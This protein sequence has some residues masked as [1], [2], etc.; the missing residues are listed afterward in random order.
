MLLPHTDKYGAAIKAEKFRRL[1]EKTEFLPE[2]LEQSELSVR[3]SI[4]VSEYPS[5][6][7][8]A[9][10]LWNAADSAYFQV[11]RVGNKVCLSAA[12]KN[13]EPDFVTETKTI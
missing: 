7:M 1:V 2:H 4:G 5:I 10:T 12:P 9:E 3:V 8:D 6:C 11:K 13:L